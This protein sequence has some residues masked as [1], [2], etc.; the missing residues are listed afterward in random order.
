MGPGGY[1]KFDKDNR[2]IFQGTEAI[3]DKPGFEN[4]FF[5]R[6]KDAQILADRHMCKDER[7]GGASMDVSQ[8]LSLLV[9]LSS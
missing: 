7:L 6:S 3:K 8:N 2:E 9:S 1:A 5:F 4:K